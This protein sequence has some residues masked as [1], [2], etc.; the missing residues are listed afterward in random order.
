LAFQGNL[1][2]PVLDDFGFKELNGRLYFDAYTPQ[3]GFEPWTVD[4]SP[5]RTVRRHLQ[6]A[7]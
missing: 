3:Y 5:R 4:P 2:L 6:V 7:K 1:P